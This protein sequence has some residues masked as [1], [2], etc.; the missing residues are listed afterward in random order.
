MKRTPI[1]KRADTT[2][3]GDDLCAVNHVRPS[4][5]RSLLFVAGLLVCA[6]AAWGCMQF[7]FAADTDMR[8]AVVTDGAGGTHRIPLGEDGSYPIETDLGTNTVAVENGEVHME[9]AD[10]PGHDCIDQ[11]AIG[12]AGEVI[13][14]LP[15]KLI[16]TIEGAAGGASTVD[17]IAS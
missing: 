15:H 9:D 13:V 16:V 2:Q 1:G 10:C 4:T 12:S 3:G 6:L 7:A 8:F 14:C 5:R 17:G 11:G